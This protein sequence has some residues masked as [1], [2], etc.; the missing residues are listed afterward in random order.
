M[1]LERQQKTSC[2]SCR[3]KESKVRYRVN[4]PKPLDPGSFEAWGVKCHSQTRK[5]L[6]SRKRLIWGSWGAA[7]VMACVCTGEGG[8]GGERGGSLM[9]V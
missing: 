7:R 9:T 3:L 5:N 8:G 6:Q 1:T 2:S 4:Q